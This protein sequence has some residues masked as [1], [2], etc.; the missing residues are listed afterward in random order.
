MKIRSVYRLLMAMSVLPFCLI[1][2][3]S[4]S[5]QST[6]NDFYAPEIVVVSPEK[7]DRKTKQGLITFEGLVLSYKLPIAE[8]VFYVNDTVTFKKKPEPQ[9]HYRYPFRFDAKLQHGQNV[10]TIVARTEKAES[11][12]SSG[13]IVYQPSSALEKPKLTVLAI[14]VSDNS[15]ADVDAFVKT[16]TQHNNCS[17][18]DLGM[19]T[20]KGSEASRYGILSGLSWLHKQSQS[21]SDVKIL[22]IRGIITQ[23]GSGN[24]YLLSSDQ[25]LDTDPELDGIELN[26]LWQR[27]SSAPG[28]LVVLL[29]VRFVGNS[30]G[31]WLERAI[32]PVGNVTVFINPNLWKSSD[33]AGNSLFASALLEG[34][35]KADASRDGLVDIQEL[36]MW[37]KKRPELA[38]SKQPMVFGYYYGSRK[39]AALTCTK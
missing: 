33:P 31:A 20:L 32:R 21:E 9:F 14:G 39:P 34:L 3:S 2:L 35:E 15:D 4:T 25:P 23:D 22:Y 7:G 36:Q 26:L 19:K 38:N 8:V 27:A 11:K 17:F 24:Y 12:F 6:N 18:A 30:S 16:I 5:A 28:P 10:V 13:R 29:D 1:T 37:L